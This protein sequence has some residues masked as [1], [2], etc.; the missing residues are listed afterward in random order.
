LDEEKSKHAGLTQ[1]SSFCPAFLLRILRLA[2]GIAKPNTTVDW[3]DIL[4][5]PGGLLL[6][7]SDLLQS[8]F[9]FYGSGWEK[10]NN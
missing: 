9:Q 8:Q 5:G 7:V 3:L 6:V 1:Q 10:V 4:I 2:K